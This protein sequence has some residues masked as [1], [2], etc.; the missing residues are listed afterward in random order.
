MVGDTGA[1]ISPL[2]AYG[3]GSTTQFHSFN[4][5]TSLSITTPTQV[6]G[7]LV[8]SAVSWATASRILG[9]NS[10]TPVSDALAPGSLSGIYI[11]GLNVSSPNSLWNGYIRAVVLYGRAMSA[12]QIQALTANGP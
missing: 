1:T 7:A 4:G 5:T 6:P 3:G 2:L 9:Y 12:A 10:L 11:G 8:R